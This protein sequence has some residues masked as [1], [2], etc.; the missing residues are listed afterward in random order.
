MTQLICFAL[1]V[2]SSIESCQTF[3]ALVSFGHPLILSSSLPS[4]PL[5]PSKTPGTPY[6]GMSLFS[7]RSSFLHI[8]PRLGLNLVPLANPQWPSNPPTVQICTFNQISNLSPLGP[9]SPCLILR[10]AG[11][12]LEFKRLENT[13]E[14]GS[15]G[16]G[17]PEILISFVPSGAPIGPRS[18]DRLSFLLVGF[19]FK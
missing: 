5:I 17:T 6:T 15:R 7:Y 2:S 4:V 18:P 12:K 3:C 1:V 8:S 10:Q 16:E 9:R 13:K 19:E 11:S 14:S